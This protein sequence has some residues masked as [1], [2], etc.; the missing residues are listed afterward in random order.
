M[1]LITVAVSVLQMTEKKSTCSS[2]K[3]WINTGRF[4]QR[5]TMLS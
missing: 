5:N 1:K 3:V 4:I 2:I